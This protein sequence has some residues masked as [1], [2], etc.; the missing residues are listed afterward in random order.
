ME[1]LFALPSGDIARY[2]ELFGVQI[3]WHIVDIYA[4]TWTGTLIDMSTLC[5][6]TTIGE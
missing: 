5:R 6:I 1:E 4:A 3:G 2:H